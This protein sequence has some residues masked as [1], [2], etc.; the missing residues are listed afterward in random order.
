MAKKT[1]KAQMKQRRDTKANWAATNPVLLDGELGIVSDDPNLYKVGDGATAWNDLPFRGFDGTLAQELGTSP[2]AVISQKVVSEKLTELESE[3]QSAVGGESAIDMTGQPGRISSTSG[4]V[5]EDSTYTH[6]YPFFVKAGSVVNFSVACLASGCALAETDANGSSYS[7]LLKGVSGSQVY[8]FSYTAPRD[9]YLSIAYKNTLAA[10]GKVTINGDVMDAISQSESRTNNIINGYTEIFNV[11]E[12]I[13]LSEGYYTLESAIAAV[14]RALRK[15]G[16]IIC[17]AASASMWKYAQYYKIGV[18]SF[19][20]TT[21]GTMSSWREVTLDNSPVFS[22]NILASYPALGCIKSVIL[23]ATR[24]D[25]KFPSLYLTR[26]SQG[27]SESQQIILNINKSISASGNKSQNVVLNTTAT[28]YA[29]VVFEAEVDNVQYEI[30]ADRSHLIASVDVQVGEENWIPMFYQSVPISL[31]L[32]KSPLIG[33]QRFVN[34]M[35]DDFLIDLSIR[36]ADKENYIYYI[37]WID[38][39]YDGANQIVLSRRHRVDNAKQSLVAINVDNYID[40]NGYVDYDRVTSALTALSY[41]RIQLRANW[42]AIKDKYDGKR[43]AFS[44]ALAPLTDIVFK[45][46]LGTFTKQNNFERLR[47]I[48]IYPNGNYFL[49]GKPVA[50]MHDVPYLPKNSY[51]DNG[52]GVIQSVKNIKAYNFGEG[53]KYSE[54]IG[55]KYVNLT[56]QF[57]FLEITQD[58]KIWLANRD[59]HNL[60]YFNNVD[61]LFAETPTIVQ[62]GNVLTNDQNPCAL[63]MNSKGELIVV[64]WSEANGLGVASNIVRVYKSDSNFENWQQVLTYNTE[65]AGLSYPDWSVKAEG[66]RILLAGYGSHTDKYQ[67][68]IWDIYYSHDGGE[69]WHSHLFRLGEMVDVD[70]WTPSDRIEQMHIHGVAI[71]HYRNRLMVMNGDTEVS[72]FVTTNLEDWEKNANKADSWNPNDANALHWK[73]LSVNDTMKYTSGIALPNC[74]LFGT[75]ALPNGFQRINIADEYNNLNECALSE[76]QW[77]AQRLTADGTGDFAFYGYTLDR[78]SPSTPVICSLM[79]VGGVQPSDYKRN[80]VY[81]TDD[82]YTFSKIWEDDRDVV[83]YNGSTFTPLRPRTIL[84]ARMTKNGD[85]L[86]QTC[87]SRFNDLVNGYPAPTSDHTLVVGKLNM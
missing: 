70:G 12:S 7:V 85:V 36:G 82:G 46:G 87:D 3:L 44:T 45:G 30:I 25:A 13:P 48:D 18:K 5:I 19:D 29:N 34:D 17:Y 33:S 78:H 80:C 26:L 86:I 20:N 39:N 6:T 4:D 73:R 40:G 1:I 53:K 9:M 49:A 68:A 15:N 74:L 54:I 57:R 64:A 61:E 8:D 65:Y 38:V 58:D 47:D 67:N 43:V 79:Y 75:D 14:P 71:D 84:T 63:K 56:R 83:S 28:D 72:L 62:I 37:D 2:N 35:G 51:Y 76:P 60:H 22:N 66:D 23:R 41:H 69:T 27:N 32:Y 21:W 31:P 81:V 24:K 52:D 42:N 59:T 10:S 77:A 16:L 50:K 55:K 11:T